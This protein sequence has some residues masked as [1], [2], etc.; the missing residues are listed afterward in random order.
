MI[1]IILGIQN[2]TL[3]TKIS[4]APY[5]LSFD[6]FEATLLPLKHRV[7]KC[8][9]SSEDVLFQKRV[10]VFHHDFHRKS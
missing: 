5:F 4:F 6:F 8:H 3:F 2:E 9:G 7:I 1:K 10:S